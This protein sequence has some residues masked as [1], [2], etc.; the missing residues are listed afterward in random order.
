MKKL[1]A[2]VVGAVLCVSSISTAQ[3]S[4]KEA[5]IYGAIGAIAGYV[6]GSKMSDNNDNRNDS[7]RNDNY[8]FEQRQRQQ[9]MQ[10]NQDPSI[11][12]FTNDGCPVRRYQ[13]TD[14]NGSSRIVLVNECRRQ[15]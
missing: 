2:I 15:N 12:Y 8:R 6:I 1:I 9:Q 3:A 14:W 13:Q 5:V 4:T 11:A 10:M 7:R